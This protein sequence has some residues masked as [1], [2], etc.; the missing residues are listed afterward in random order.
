MEDCMSVST[1]NISFQTDL[2]GQIDEIA[3]N[4]ARTRSELIREAVRMYIERKK[5][6]NS[7]FEIGEGIGSKLDISEKDIMQEIK[8]YRK[9][10]K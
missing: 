6:W 1:V 3:R 5:E 7:L 9:T 2:L 10:K 4:E 8:E